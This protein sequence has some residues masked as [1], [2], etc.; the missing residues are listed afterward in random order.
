M[1]VEQAHPQHLLAV[2][3]VMLH[4]GVVDR[5]DAQIVEAVDEHRHRI[6]VEQQ[7]ERRLALLH[8]GDVDAQPDDAAV[9][10]AALLDQDGAAVGQRLLVAAVRIEQLVEPLLHPFFFAAE[11]LRI[12]A[13]LDAD[14]QRVGELRAG[15]EQVG[16]A[17]VDV[18]VLLVPQDVA[19]VGIEEHDAFRQDVDGVAQPR[20]GLA[21]LQNGE[22]GLGFGAPGIGIA[23]EASPQQRGDACKHG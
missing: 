9:A 11:R 6:A 3:A 16:A 13:A 14:A 1:D 15:L 22:R 18:G 2:V 5:Q 21:R 19:A 12:V 4:R 17:L 8:L 10:G 23:C 7:P 20:G